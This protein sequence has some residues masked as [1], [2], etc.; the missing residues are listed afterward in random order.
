M[1]E[2]KTGCDPGLPTKALKLQS[3]WMTKL[4]F[5]IAA[6]DPAPL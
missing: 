4:P 3:T 2:E 1:I 5:Q 6:S